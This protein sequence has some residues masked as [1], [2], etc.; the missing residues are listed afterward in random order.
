MPD[1]KRPSAARRSCATS[2]TLN[3]EVSRK[4]FLEV[5]HDA[6]EYM[7]RDASA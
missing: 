5:Y 7:Q 4:N 6:L 3:K 2:S 1:R